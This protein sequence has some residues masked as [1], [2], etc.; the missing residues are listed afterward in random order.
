MAGILQRLTEELQRIAGVVK[1]RKGLEE[2]EEK[3]SAPTDLS[4]MCQQ[5]QVALG[6]AAKRKKI[7]I[8]IDGLGR[9]EQVSRTSKV[10]NKFKKRATLSPAPPQFSCC[11]V[12]FSLRWYL[13]AREGPYAPHPVS[14]EFPQCCP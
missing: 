1:K 9:M 12:H 10:K 8:V 5:L 11:S 7:L 6:K 3:D 4:D 14:E 13:C 2:R